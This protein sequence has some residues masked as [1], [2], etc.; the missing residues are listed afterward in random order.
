[1][2]RFTIGCRAVGFGLI[3]AVAALPAQAA[4]EKASAQPAVKSPLK[5]T[6]VSQK[7]QPTLSQINSG[8]FPI[9]IKVT[10]TG[11]ESVVIF[12]FL[13]MAVLDSEEEPVK[14]TRSLGR[15]GFRTTNSMIEG[16]PFKTLAPGKSYSFDVKVSLY[17]HDPLLISA[18]KFPKPGDYELVF[19]Y[20]YDR[21]AAKKSFGRGCKVL[22]DPKQLW[23]Q[24]IETKQTL[25]IP[26]TIR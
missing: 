13:S 12:G 22:D 19:N 17:T 10:N 15:W 14:K 8:R 18:W 11:K 23:N 4:K 7:K 2:P 21:K 24:A 16:M 1:M 6:T 9:S 5:F 3:L 20:E 25:R 26:L